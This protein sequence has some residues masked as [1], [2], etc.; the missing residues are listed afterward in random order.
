ML[1]SAG[2]QLG[3]VGMRPQV[4]FH[5]AVTRGTPGGT[6]GCLAVGPEELVQTALWILST[7][8]SNSKYSIQSA[9]EALDLTIRLR[10]LGSYPLMM[11]C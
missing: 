9:H 6:V 10:P 11:D 1:I 3:P 2:L 4:S 8:H 5:Q 7:F